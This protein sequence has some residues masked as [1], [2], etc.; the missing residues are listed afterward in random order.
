MHG[1]V[2]YEADGEMKPQSHN[3]GGQEEKRR[4]DTGPQT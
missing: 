1:T 3:E 2:V 4:A